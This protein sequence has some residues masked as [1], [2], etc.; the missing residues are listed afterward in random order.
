MATSIIAMILLGKF[1][2]TYLFLP[3][4]CESQMEVILPL[5]SCLEELLVVAVGEGTS[6]TNI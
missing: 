2:F 3:L 4:I 6:G 1:Q 5:R